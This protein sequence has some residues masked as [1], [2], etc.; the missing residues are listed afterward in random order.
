MRRGR[1]Q[2]AS[3][4]GGHSR[5]G[6]ALPDATSDVALR[7][8]AAIYSAPL[9]GSEGGLR[10]PWRPQTHVRGLAPAQ[11]TGGVMRVSRAFLPCGREGG[12]HLRASVRHVRAVWEGRVRGTGVCRRTV[13][14][15][16]GVGGVVSI[17]SCNDYRYT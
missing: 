10:A 11:G 13:P 6:A 7:A 2:E 15:G 9:S 12:R 8:E 16:R 14:R 4:T 17:N 1:L 3:R 5:Y